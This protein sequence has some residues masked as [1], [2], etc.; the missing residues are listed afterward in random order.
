MT[1]RSQQWASENLCHVKRRTPNYNKKRMNTPIMDTK[2]NRGV[3]DRHMRKEE[4]SVRRLYR[5]VAALRVI[6]HTV[7]VR[8]G[9]LRRF[10]LRNNEVRR[11][12]HKRCFSFSNRSLAGLTRTTTLRIDHIAMEDMPEGKL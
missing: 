9:N 10:K 11:I 7:L 4:Q 3:R 5:L 6:D 12:E 2:S 8:R 1:I